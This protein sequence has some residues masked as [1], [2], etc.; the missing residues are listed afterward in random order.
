[1]ARQVGVKAYNS[2]IRG[3][4][5][6]ASALTYPENASIDEANFLLNRDGSR[7]RRLGMD[8]ENLYSMVDTGVVANTFKYYSIS[9]YRW[10]NVGSDITKSFAVVQV[11]PDLWFFDLFTSVLSDNIKNGGAS[12]SVGVNGQVPYQF[13]SINGDLI[14]ATKETAPKRIVYNSST[15]SFTVTSLNIKIRDL[16]GVDD[17]LDINTKP[18]SLSTTHRYNLYNQGWN[19]SRVSSY[20]SY[21]SRY[22]SNAQTWYTGKDADDVFSPELLDKHDFGTTPAPKGRY[23]IDA[24]ARGTSRASQSGLSV[25]SD[26]DNGYIGSVAAHSGR[27]FY[28]GIISSLT[29]GDDMSPSYTGYI[30]FS[31]VLTSNDQ[32]T[33][34]YQAGDPTTEFTS[35]VIDTDGGFISIPE[36]SNIL[37]LIS[38][39]EHLIV[40]AENGVWQVFGGDRGF[41]ATEYQVSKITNIGAVNAESVVEAEGIIYYWSKG[42]IYALTPDQISGNFTSVNITTSTI[43]TL[44]NNIASVAKANVV[45]SYDSSSKKVTWLY[46]NTS[47]YDGT[48]YRN[49]YDTELIVDTTIEAFYKHTISSLSSNT[50]YVAGY[51]ITPNFV[52]AQDVQ[53]VV[54]NGEQVQVNGEDV[55]ITS[56][57]RSRGLSATKYVT[58]VPGITNYEFTF[59]NY[60]DSNFRDWYSTDST[61]AYFESYLITGHELFGDVV[62]DKQTPYIF[63]YFKRTET[64]FTG[65]GN[66]FDLDNP[67][68]C[69]VQSRWEWTDSATSGRWGTAF[70]AYRLN[71]NYIPDNIDDPF[72]YGFDV[73]ITKSKLRGKGKALSIKFYSENGKDMHLLGWAT[74][75]SAVTTP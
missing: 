47:T 12:L 13:S 7:Q 56:D 63:C 54:V 30:F 61:G 55:V 45:G 20:Y 42:G 43:Q 22:P 16:Y 57:V 23:I 31:Q 75:M 62:R 27:M 18:T 64:G 32:L 53:S 29:D 51:M 73:I 33:K 41:L 34:C 66:T 8:Y 60:K 3:L 4:N 68:S 46:N 9:T 70:Q 15:D 38:A 21:G 67:S 5:T 26:T 25:S 24:F 59:S 39:K 10:D 1:M 58:V 6:E 52:T 71:R 19:G 36:A 2:F 17:G 44:Y 48:V 37:K 65:S 72:D 50:P 35:D 28:S 11:G 74:T 49:T 40:I 14:V 69:F